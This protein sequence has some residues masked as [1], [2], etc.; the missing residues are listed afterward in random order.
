[1]K[2]G[3][4]IQN[5]V[6]LEEH[7]YTKVKLFLETGYDVSLIPP[8]QAKGMST[9]DMEMRGVIWEMKAP[10]GKSRN[11]IKH[12]FQNACHQSP[13]VIIDLQRCKLTD[14]EALKDIRY[15]YKTS[16]RIKRLIVIMKDKK[17]IDI[18]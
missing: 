9:P 14:D 10:Q 6:H 3:K 13:N 8:I 16:K 15:H 11:T 18:S 17:I 4:L 2:N 7:E 5:G 1:M 12:T